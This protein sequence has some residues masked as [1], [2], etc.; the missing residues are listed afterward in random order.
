MRKS[1]TRKISEIINEFLQ[2][3][4]LK[5]KLNKSRVI[6]YWE[7]LMG[8]TIAKRTT[9]IYIK[10]KTLF[11]SFSSSVVKSEI[12]MMRKEIVD[13]L[14]KHVGEIIVEKIVIR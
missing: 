3:S 7:E 12:M 9:S 2:E 14:N 6:N 8:K 11:V 1:N 5:H 13:A 10:N 4:G